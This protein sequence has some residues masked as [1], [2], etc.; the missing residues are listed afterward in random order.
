MRDVVII[1]ADIRDWVRVSTVL[2]KPSLFHH[3]TPTKLFHQFHSKAPHRLSYIAFGDISLVRKVPLHTRDSY[4]S[5]ILT[6]IYLTSL[7]GIVSLIS[8]IRNIVVLMA[9]SSKG[10]TLVHCDREFI[11]HHGVLLHLP[12]C[13]GLLSFPPLPAQRPHHLSHSYLWSI[14]PP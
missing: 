5:I 8:I 3:Q 13:R 2:D 7:Q 9:F 12:P 11:P 4:F 1:I 6:Y 14:G 10:S